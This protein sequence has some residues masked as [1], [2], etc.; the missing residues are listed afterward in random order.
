MEP[1]RPD[2]IREVLIVRGGFASAPIVLSMTALAASLDAPQL[3]V[4]DASDEVEARSFLEPRQLDHLYLTG[5]VWRHGTALDPRFGELLGWFVDG[6]LRGLFLYST[7]VVIACDD[8]VGVA[9]FVRYLHDERPSRRVAQIVGLQDEVA[10]LWSG[11]A[12]HGVLPAPRRVSVG[13]P[14]LRVT[15]HDLREASSRPRLRHRL[16]QAGDF[17]R[18]LPICRAMTLEELGVDPKAVDPQGFKAALRVRLREGREF[19]WEDRGDIVF[20][21]AIAALTP[22]GALIEGV[23]TLPERRSEGIATEALYGVLAY[24]LCKRPAVVLAVDAHNHA[25]RRV[26][27]RLGFQPIGRCTS[28][29]FGQRGAQPRLLQRSP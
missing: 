9:H 15:T 28:L 20:R 27:D 26:Y 14:L 7:V 12:R 16:A 8:P 11:I 5:L 22:R 21:V 25:A 19:L 6:S 3:R 4:L 23:Y 2:P 24:L 17:D 10:W 29:L 18:L 1:T 13:Q